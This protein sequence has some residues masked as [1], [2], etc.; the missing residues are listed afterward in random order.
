MVLA[1]AKWATRGTVEAA[2]EAIQTKKSVVN[3]GGGYHHAKSPKGEGFCFFADIPLACKH[4]WDVYPDAKILV[5]DLDNHQGNGVAS[6]REIDT[7]YFEKM[8]I[9]DMYAFSG[10]PYDKGERAKYINFNYPLKTGISSEEYLSILKKELTSVLE[11]YSFDLIIYNAGTD[12]FREDPLGSMNISQEGI[13]DRDAFVFS[14]AKSHDIPI[15]MV[16]SGG[17]TQKSAE[18][19]AES[20]KN[21]IAKKLF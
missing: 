1:P 5:V 18:I 6:Y 3:L 8:S 9:F 19:I 2:L 12:I 10:Y 16:L 11:N 7:Q 4:I 14:I 21:I 20:L 15:C 17:Y 13:V